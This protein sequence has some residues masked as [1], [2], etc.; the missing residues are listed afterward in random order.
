MNLFNN[1][2]TQLGTGDQIKDYKHASR[3]FV[4]NNYALSPKYD[5]MYHVFFDVNP[6]LSRIQNREALTETGM[7]VKSVD[8]PKF[9][10]E[11][12][13]FNNYNRP[14]IVQ[15]KIKY[16]QIQV[17]FHDDQ[18][19]VVRNFWYDYYNYYY[20]DSD[21]GITSGAGDVNPTYYAKNKYNGGDRTQLNRFGYSPR[22]TDSN[23]GNQ[24]INA[25]RIYSLHQKK[26]TEYIL[27]NP[28]IVGF[29]HGSH[30]AS[31]NGILEHS[32]TIQY[33]SVL[34]CSGYVSVNT[35][36]GFADLHYDK[37]PSPLSAAGGGT[38]SIM[39]P[40]GIVSA[41]DG[42]VSDPVK[43]AF[44]LARVF[45]KNKNVNLGQIAKA[46]ALT[47]LK[48]VLN[49]QD[50]RN[51]FFVPTGAS[52]F[53]YTGA[54]TTAAAR[55]YPPAGQVAGGSAI[56]NGVSIVAGGTAIAAGAAIGTG[57]NVTGGQLNSIINLN[58]TGSQTGSSAQ[59]G[60]NFLSTSLKKIQQKLKTE[61]DQQIAATRQQQA[62]DA[63]KM[64]A[65]YAA[66]GAA[67]EAYAA[68]GV[69]VF[70]TS[71][72]TIVSQ[73]S[74]ILGQTAYGTIVAPPSSDVAST[75]AVAFVTNGNPQ[76]VQPALSFAG[77]QAGSST[78]P[79]PTNGPVAI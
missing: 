7:L 28:K 31:Q 1:F 65:G 22:N 68:K 44:G 69:P 74:T 21:I 55:Y 70:E 38:N 11:T 34:Y 40:G 56:S 6:Q 12:K 14:N 23:F 25:I 16:D 50:P 49:G 30:N 19:N 42:F 62:V 60:F 43:G 24:Y 52:P 53:A 33:E 76:Q 8:L 10:V 57:T 71:S 63:Q 18:S 27:V 72:S 58:N 59:I 73:P 26:F 2:L 15:S 41:I 46:E 47:A 13:T 9:S 61:S 79:I 54:A 48:D 78:N 77:A 3:L 37:S 5:W 45:Q 64:S 39:G 36:K 4:D 32:M 66:A 17:T 51:R 29:S 35:V 67:S 75:Q 20:R